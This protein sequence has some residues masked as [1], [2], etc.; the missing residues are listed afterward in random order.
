MSFAVAPD[1]GLIVHITPL[2]EKIVLL[3]FNEYSS[4]APASRI[5]A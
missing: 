3:F 5:L 2:H 1:L 4:R